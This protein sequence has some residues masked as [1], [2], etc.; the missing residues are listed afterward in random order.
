MAVYQTPFTARGL[1]VAFASPAPL[2]VMTTIA[3]FEV[4]AL[5]VENIV[6]TEANV[7]KV[8]TSAGR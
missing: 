8:K 7:S 3:T 1:S 4:F 5:A 2:V 6:E